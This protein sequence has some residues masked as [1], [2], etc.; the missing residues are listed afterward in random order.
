MYTSFLLENVHGNVL[1]LGCGS[2]LIASFLSRSEKIDNIVVMD[3]SR[4]LIENVAPEIMDLFK[5][6]RKKIKFVVGDFHDLSRFKKEF[7]FVVFDGSLHHSNKPS[8]VL[9]GCNRLLK[10]GG[11]IFGV[12][13]PVLPKWLKYQRKSFG[14]GQK[15]KGATENIYTLDEWKSLFKGSGFDFFKIPFIRSGLGQ[16]LWMFNNY[17]FASYIIGGKRNH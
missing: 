6:D 14:A 4:N 17:L 8:V 11:I 9:D 10:H 15:K 1:M 12:D 2:G 16:H 5:A 13:E 3:F 7:D